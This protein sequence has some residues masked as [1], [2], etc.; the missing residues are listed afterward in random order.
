MSIHAPLGS[1]Q[2]DTTT[3]PKL[4]TDSIYQ[5]SL[6]GYQCDECEDRSTTVETPQFK[7][8]SKYLIVQAMRIAKKLDGLGNPLSD[9]KGNTI[10][11]KIHREIESPEKI[12]LSA[13]FPDIEQNSSTRYE[14]FGMI[15]HHGPKS[16]LH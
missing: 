6:D 1:R 10:T 14:L 12:N 5:Q 16:V 8:A 2:E 3:L 7:E 9:R 13:L 15:S 4:L 11:E